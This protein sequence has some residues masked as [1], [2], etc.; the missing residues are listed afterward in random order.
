MRKVNLIQVLE[1]S[2]TKIIVHDKRI[3]E[4]TEATMKSGGIRVSLSSC[5]FLAASFVILL[6]VTTG[7]FQIFYF[8]F[9][10]YEFNSFKSYNVFMCQ[11]KSGTYS[12]IR[13]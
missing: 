11:Q 10:L 7:K 3:C 5:G 6:A 12:N 8:I 1:V 2:V 9:F 13:L 4:A